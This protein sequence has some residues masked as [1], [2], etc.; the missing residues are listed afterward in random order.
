MDHAEPG[1][2]D[3]P[4]SEP[5]QQPPGR[6]RTGRNRQKWTCTVTAEVTIV[7]EAAV[8]GA[9]EQYVADSV[10]IDAFSGAVIEDPASQEA[11]PDPSPPPLGQLPW[12]LWPT[13][14]LG[15]L[16]EQGAFRVF[17]VTSDLTPQAPDRGALTWSVTIKLTDV[18]VLRRLA[19]RAHPE[20]ADLI[21]GSLAV[22]WQ[23]A[24]DP[25]APLRSIP[26]IEWQPLSVDIEHVPA[27]VARTR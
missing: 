4:E 14:G 18:H 19:T 24:A 5:K 6:T 17:E 11:G 1:L 22:A 9:I 26:G 25:L 2:F 12:L 15:E 13:R 23:R 20:D 7:D 21:A 10:V 3:L 8:K 27:G 16:L